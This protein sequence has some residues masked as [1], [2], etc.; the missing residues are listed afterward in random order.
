MKKILL[1]LLVIF[2]I[3]IY[4]TK[5]KNLDHD[6][7][8]NYV[9]NDTNLKTEPLPSAPVK[10]VSY[11]KNENKAINNFKCDGRQHCSQMNSCEE[12]KFFLKNCP[13]TKMDGD[14]DGVPCERDLCK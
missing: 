11:Y 1:L 4:N 2:G 6:L 5:N 14:Y 10:E 3:F 12:A 9:Q 7:Q 13:N 8:S